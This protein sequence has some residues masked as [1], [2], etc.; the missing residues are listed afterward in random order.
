M[1][2]LC[3]KELKCSKL[4]ECSAIKGLAK[5]EHEKCTFPLFITAIYLK[6]C[7]RRVHP[8]DPSADLKNL[9]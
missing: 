8:R 3:V 4:G 9:I 6:V 5:G 2:L 1:S 7:I